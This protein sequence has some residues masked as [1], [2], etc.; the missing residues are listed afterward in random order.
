M[1]VVRVG[2]RRQKA[3]YEIFLQAAPAFYP[4]GP[5]EVVISEAKEIFY[6]LLKKTTCLELQR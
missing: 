6:G 3:A 2:R 5:K 1:R 4:W